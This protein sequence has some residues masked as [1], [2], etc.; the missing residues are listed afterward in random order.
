MEPPLYL[1]RHAKAG[2]RARWGGPDKLRPLSKK[3]RRQ[4]EAL[5]AQLEGRP[6]ARL[7]TSPALRCVQTLEPLAAVLGLQLTASDALLEGSPFEVVRP[8]FVEAE[9]MGGVV[10]CSHGDILSLLLEWLSERGVRLDGPSSP[11]KGSI[12]ILE[13]AEGVIVTGHYLAPEF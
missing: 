11:T 9:S 12:W 3:G 4:A 13:R 1:V 6:I 10:L 2:S 5:V 7:L 8:G